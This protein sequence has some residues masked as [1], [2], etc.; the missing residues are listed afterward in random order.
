[1]SLKIAS[2]RLPQVS[3]PEVRIPMAPRFARGEPAPS[4]TPR[5]LSDGFE[6]AAPGVGHKAPSGSRFEGVGPALRPLPKRLEQSTRLADNVV[7][8]FA[9]DAR[10]RE[11]GRSD[12]S[13]AR[14]ILQASFQAG[15]LSSRDARFLTNHYAAPQLAGALGKSK[16][17]G[18][19][20]NQG[21][22]YSGN[23][24]E[25]GLSEEQAEELAAIRTTGTTRPTD[26][27]SEFTRNAAG[28]LIDGADLSQFKNW[29]DVEK[30]TN[31]V[32]RN[33]P[34]Q[35]GDSKEALKAFIALRLGDRMVSEGSDLGKNLGGK[36]G[37]G[38]DVFEGFQALSPL[39]DR[40]TR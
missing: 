4:A 12:P 11:L 31:E 36:I 27:L 22:D 23:N 8:F 28:Q 35:E 7:K 15:G 33:V 37:S 2:P 40:Y 39:Q 25:S 3:R 14:Q 32:L 13:K 17:Q 30:F 21:L 16:L 10:L 19:G 9:Q 20:A 18:V 34:L 5:R 1:M 26:G 6:R 29:G 38:A 24:V